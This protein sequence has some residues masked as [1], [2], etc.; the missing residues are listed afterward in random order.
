MAHVNMRIIHS[1][2]KGGDSRTHG[3]CRILLV[4]WLLGPVSKKVS[5][6]NSNEDSRSKLPTV[7][8]CL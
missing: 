4:I 2:S 7:G 8:T 3:F 5:A 1:G 6:Q